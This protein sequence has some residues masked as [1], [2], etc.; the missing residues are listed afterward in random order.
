[1]PQPT[2][3]VAGGPARPFLLLTFAGG[4]RM[5][6]GMRFAQ[7]EFK[8]I[9]AHVLGTLTLVAREGDIAHAGFWNARPAAPMRVRMRAR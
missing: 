4:A 8:A 5:C 6:L 1:M 2:P 9:V 7:M 3:R